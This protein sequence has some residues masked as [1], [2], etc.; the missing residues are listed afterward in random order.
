MGR[1]GNPINPEESL[2]AYYGWKI[3]KFREDRG[4]SQTELGKKI[5]LSTDAVSKLELGKSAP[6]DRTGDLLDSTFGTDYFRDHA[7]LVRKERVP[8]AVRSLAQSEESAVK[9]NIYEP[10]LI[11]GLFQTEDYMRAIARAYLHADD[12]DAI[13]ADR[14][15]R[16]Q[17]LDRTPPPRILLVMDEEALRRPIGGPGVLQA[18]LAYLE[19]LME[20]VTIAVQVVPTTVGAH[21][22]LSAAFTLLSFADAQDVA[23]IEGP[24]RGTGQFLDQSSAVADLSHTYDLIRGLASPVTETAYLIREIRESL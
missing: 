6:D 11:T 24:V 13:V 7:L 14:L 22:G 9:I 19:S 2:T 18:Q 10:H 15:A 16:Q 17:V 23:Y 12:V 3:R 4:W 8:A 1:P 5:A 20:S 21:A